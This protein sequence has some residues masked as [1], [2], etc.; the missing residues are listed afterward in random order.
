MNQPR[1]SSSKFVTVV[2]TRTHTFLGCWVLLTISISLLPHTFDSARH[3]LSWCLSTKAQHSIYTNTIY[4]SRRRLAL[5]S[6]THDAASR[7]PT[8]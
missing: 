3:S 5:S 1:R 2:R 8:A 6:T 7:P 4:T